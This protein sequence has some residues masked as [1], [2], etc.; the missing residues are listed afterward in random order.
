MRIL[1]GISLALALALFPPPPVARAFPTGPPNFRTWCGSRGTSPVCGGPVCST[2]AGC[3]NTFGGP[4][5]GSGSVAIEG[6][7]AGYLPG[8]PYALTVL[9][10]DA[11]NP[12]FSIGGFELSALAA[13]GFCQAGTLAPD[14]AAMR[15]DT[16]APTSTR[17]LKQS[18]PQAAVAGSALWRF[19]WTAPDPPAGDVVLSLCGNA[20]DG[21]TGPTNDHIYC[22][23]Y[24]VPVAAPLPEPR[25][26]LAKETA[27]GQVGITWAETAPCFH[28]YRG[29]IAEAGPLVTTTGAYQSVQ[30]GVTGN[31]AADTAL[32]DGADWFY[33]VVAADRSGEGSYG[34]TDTNGDGACD[35]DRVAASAPCPACP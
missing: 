9:L 11:T 13:T 5:T 25:I 26:F 19:L 14:G 23:D 3:H 18:S 30:C 28:V 10:D 16:D 20:A 29:A 12:E 17:W 15:V 34:C 7:P 35:A 8:L 1:R 33:L 27:A 31:T 22:A 4:N 6:L 24:V 2:C 21:D 32:A